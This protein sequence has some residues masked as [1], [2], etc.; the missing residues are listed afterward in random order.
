MYKNPLVNLCKIPTDKNAAHAVRDRAALAQKERL[1]SEALLIERR[2]LFNDNIIDKINVFSSLDCD[3]V[4]RIFNIHI[5]FNFCFIVYSTN[6]SLS[7]IMHLRGRVSFL[8]TCWSAWPL[9]GSGA[10]QSYS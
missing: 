1:I 7:S 5:S 6:S 2:G 4:V 3:V 8:P 9:H 10:G